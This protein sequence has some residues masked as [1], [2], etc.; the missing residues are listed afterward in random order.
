MIKPPTAINGK[1]KWSNRLGISKEVWENSFTLLL[2]TTKDSKL[3][4][5]QIRILH[6]I[7]T[8]NRSVSKF[9]MQQNDA[10]TFCGSHSE[11]ISHL[12]WE[13]EN[14]QSFWR[15]LS[16]LL[17][18]RCSNFHNFKFNVNLVLFGNADHFSIDRTTS[19]IILMGKFHI[20]RCKVQNA[21]L[22]LSSFIRE[23]YHRYQIE[24]HTQE[25]S[26]D[27][28]SIWFPY[29]QLFQSLLWNEA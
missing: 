20:Y 16:D 4:W 18:R 12:L 10:C 5:F 6:S 17:N 13:C 23:L 14:V 28:K 15:K 22:N 19:L 29:I 24:L 7:L 11:T 9:K 25:N 8:T 27:F 1:G 3:Q 26:N 2:K 21:P